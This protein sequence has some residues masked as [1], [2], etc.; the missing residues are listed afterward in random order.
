MTQIFFNTI[1]YI[2]A[3]SGIKYG[4]NEQTDIAMRVL[5]DHIRAI[6]F[7]I[8][9]GQLPSNNKAGYGYSQNTAKSCSVFVYLSEL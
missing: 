1:N 7:T 4:S 6:A 5:S 3:M 2:E 8:A 9:D